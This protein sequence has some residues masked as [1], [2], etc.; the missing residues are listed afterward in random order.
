LVLAA[1]LL[2]SASYA[3]AADITN[4]YTNNLFA[5]AFTT[6]P[7]TGVSIGI[8]PSRVKGNGE[9]VDTLF[10]IVSGPFGFATIQGTLPKN[11][12]HITA[13]SASLEVD[14]ADMTDVVN[15]GFPASGVVSVDWHATGVE[16]TSGS[17]K[18]E[19]GNVTATNVGTATFSPADVEGTFLG[20]DLIDPGGDLSLAHSSLHIHISTN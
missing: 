13:H 15:S 18:Q 7:S 12:L 5:S 6:D 20:A 4:I 9:P 2:L 17:F 3:R 8:F 1:A 16:R 11:A 19:F 10:M 14:I